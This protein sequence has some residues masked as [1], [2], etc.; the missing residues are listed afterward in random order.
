MLQPRG[1][2]RQ[3]GGSVQVF[4]GTMRVFLTG[5]GV[6]QVERTYE[7][8]EVAVLTGLQPARLRAW[9]R[10][11]EVVRPQ[12]LANGYRR[13]TADQ[14]ALLGAFA[15]LIEAG[16]RIGHLAITAPDEVLARARDR[17]RHP[18]PDS[19]FIDAIQAL[20]R[21]RLEGIVAQQLALRGLRGF[22]EAIVLPLA[23]TIGELW[24]LGVMPIAAEH[25]ASEV[26][27]HALKGGL[28]SLRG[29]GRLMLAACL[30]GERHEWGIL[31]MLAILQEEGWRAHYLGAD[32]PLDDLVNAAGRLSPAAVA[33]SAND[34]ETVRR[35]LSSLVALPG[36]LPAGTR[37]AI[38]GKGAEAHA[39]LLQRYGYQVGRAGFAWAGSL[40]G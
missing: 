14:V 39:A 3:R 29:D 9:E 5:S 35:S 21:E 26:I 25:L 30:P 2:A 34:P 18:A 16:E 19:A 6:T 15:R 37:L 24:A 23:E 22:A 28:R 31:A 4:D 33:L 8:H 27:L 7:I 13:Y 12:R 32:L 20:D 40:R 1:R 36:Q 11:Y 38:G 10:R 17:D